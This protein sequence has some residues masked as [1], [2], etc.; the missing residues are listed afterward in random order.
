M[1]IKDMNEFVR[2]IAIIGVGN[3]LMGDEGV[4]IHA[5]E[6]L[7][8]KKWPDDV[9]IIDAGTPGVSLL[10]LIEGRKLVVIIDCADFGGRAG[11][12]RTFNPDNLQRDEKKE[13]SLHATDL[14]STL[15]LAKRTN[16]YPEKIVIVGIQPENVSPSS[17]LSASAT[18][19]LIRL[20]SIVRKI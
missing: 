11:E 2:S 12:V 17:S 6:N 5:I 10:H 15:E 19:A 18:Q 20:E 4:G 14:L 3:Y 7:R 1:P 8:S 9:E 13:I 16:N